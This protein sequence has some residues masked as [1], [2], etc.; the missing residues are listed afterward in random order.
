[1]HPKTGGR[2]LALEN[3][4]PRKFSQN[5][6][7]NAPPRKFSQNFIVDTNTDNRNF[8]SSSQITNTIGALEAAQ[9]EVI[10]E[11]VFGQIHWVDQKLL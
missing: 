1:M 7:V 3:A 10:L 6:I 11:P 2:N 4:P 9:L 8:W 5:F